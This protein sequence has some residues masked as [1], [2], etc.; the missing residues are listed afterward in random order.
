[1]YAAAVASLHLSDDD[2]Y[3]ELLH[4]IDDVDVL[5]SDPE[6]SSA[7]H[8]LLHPTLPDHLLHLHALQSESI[9]P[10]ERALPRFTRRTLQRIP[11]WELW[12]ENETDQIDQMHELGM[13][14][15]PCSLPPDG[16]ALRFHWT[17]RIKTN[18]KRRSRVCCDGSPRAAPAVHSNTDTYA[19]CLEHP[20]FR[21]FVALSATEN[22]TIYGGDAKDAFAH[23]PAPTQPTFMRIDDAFAEWYESSTNRKLD[24]SLVLPV[25]CAFQG[26]PEAA[27]LWEEHIHSIVHSLGFR[28]TTHERNIYTATFGDEKV[29]MVRQVDDF[30]LACRTEDVAKDIF[31]RIGA[32]LKLDGEASAPFEYLGKVDMYNGYD[33]LQTAD[34]IK[35]SASS[36]LRRLLKSHHWE[37][38]GAHE[39]STKP[40]P[41]LHESTIASLYQLP[42]GP[43]EGTI[44][45]AQLAEKH[46][47]GYRNLLGKILFAYV[48]CRPD[49]GYAVTTLA[50]FST[51]PNDLHYQSLKHLAL[52]L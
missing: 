18:G 2:P 12:H 13:F 38:P 16:I 8:Y 47:F 9:T 48:L 4:N 46:G 52:Y 3:E 36:Y 30:A 39:H 41:P 23:A 51:A 40:K 34:Y 21:L 27:K 11:T 14:G 1:M 15:D 29:L 6:V 26:H 7:I 33:V 20:I 17:Y 31:A 37:T 28:N 10:E 19:S 49:I 24:R 25:L 50:K 35:I 22:L 44:E 45:H 32:A 42:A 43:K 5:L